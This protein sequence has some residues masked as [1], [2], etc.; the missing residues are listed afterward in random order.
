MLEKG[1]WYGDNMAKVITYGTFDLF[2]EGH[3]GLQWRA[4]DLGEYLI[5]G[6]TLEEYDQ[7]RGKPNI[8]GLKI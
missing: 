6:V 8:Q 5:V 2:H 3:Y 1:K 4:K 7:T